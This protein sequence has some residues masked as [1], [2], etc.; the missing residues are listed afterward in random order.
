MGRLGLL[1]AAAGALAL[2]FIQQPG[3]TVDDTKLPLVMSPLAFMANSLHLW[4][5]DPYS[6]SVQTATYGYLAADGPLLRPRRG[7]PC[8]GVDHR[9]GVAGPFAHGVV[10]G[11]RAPGRGPRHQGAGRQG[12]RRGGL[13]D[14]AHRRHQC[15]HLGLPPGR[16]P[17]ALGAGAPRPRCRRRVTA[18]RCRCIGDSHRADGRRERHRRAGRC[19]PSRSSGCS[20]VRAAL[21]DVP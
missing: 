15:R 19:S 14:R 6:G 17:L 8:P 20:P 5:P 1:F 16:R 13:H 10:L 4:N 11:R 18:P 7:P 12:G 9:E 3:N 2:A 21:A